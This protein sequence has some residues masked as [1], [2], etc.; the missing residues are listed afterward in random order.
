MLEAHKMAVERERWAQ[1]YFVSCM[2]SVHLKNGISAS[3]IV[4]PFLEVK[5]SRGAEAE[6]FWEDWE[7]QRKEAENAEKCKNR[8]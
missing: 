3:K 8:G 2:M 4:K 5:Q 6:A 7:R 1:S